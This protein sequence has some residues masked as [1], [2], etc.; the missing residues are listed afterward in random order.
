MTEKTIILTLV[1]VVL[2]QTVL[3]EGLHL[4]IRLCFQGKET[5][6]LFGFVPLS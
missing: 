6:L 5:V 2:K 4:H 3:K 1:T